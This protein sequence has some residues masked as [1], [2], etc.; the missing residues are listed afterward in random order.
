MTRNVWLIDLNVRSRRRASTSANV[1]VH[2]T[3]G[4]DDVA[5]AAA[6]AAKEAW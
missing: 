2:S 4:P 3:V 5:A 6:A 1:A